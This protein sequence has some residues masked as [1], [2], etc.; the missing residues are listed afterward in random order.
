MKFR[1]VPLLAIAGSLALLVG[2]LVPQE[3]SLGP[4]GLSTSEARTIPQAGAVQLAT[5]AERLAEVPAQAMLPLLPPDS[6]ASMHPVERAVALGRVLASRVF[7]SHSDGLWIRERLVQTPVQPRPVRVV[8]RWDGHPSLQQPV[9]LSREMFLADQLI[10]KASSGASTEALG[11]ALEAGGM[12][13][14]QAIAEGV[15]TVCLPQANLDAVPAALAF[16]AQHPDLVGY[17]EPDGVGFGGSLP[18]DTHFALQWG[19]NNTGQAGG[20]PGVDVA[21]PFLWGSLSSAAGVVVAVLDSGLNFAHPDLQGISW[22]DPT[23]IPNDG[24]DNSGSGRID[25]Y[26]GWDFVNNDNDPTDDHGHGS[27][28][29]G[30]IAANRNNAVG[31]AGMLDGVQILVLKILNASNSGSTSNLIAATTYARQ[32]GVP[33]MNLSLQSYPYNSTLFNEFTAC[34]TAGIL[35]S[36]CAG[37]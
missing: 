3:R 25:D 26:R 9:C 13:V 37:N 30:I 22:I 7:P 12:R 20:T 8:E 36:I 14:D 16:L 33:I 31:I 29:T 32:R 35:L 4:G 15:Y 21:A 23:E 1:S 6:V 18:N 10:V 2:L 27:N 5:N 28:V 24:I 17:A 11:Q 34:E 19:L